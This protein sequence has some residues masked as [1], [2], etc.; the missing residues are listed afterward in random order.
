MEE[1]TLVQA[2]ARGD[3]TAWSEFVDRYAATLHDAA[4]FTLGRVL[5]RSQEEDVENVVQGVFLGL[6]DRDCHRLRLF[7]G[8]SSLRTWLTSVTARFAL[9][10]IRTE[11]RKGSLKYS[12]L[13]EGAVGPPD[14]REE[15]P[16][17]TEEREHLFHAMERMGQRERLL[18]KLFYYDGLSYKA[19]SEFLGIPLNSVSPLIT[20][21]RE[22]LRKR[23]ATP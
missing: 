9:N 8:R 19:I 10:Y 21:A 20:R 13:D 4:R 17:T 22:S 6:C 7:Q 5:G 16:L 3:T 11:K 14:E 23:I 12:G 15:D 2:C 1:Q 18:L